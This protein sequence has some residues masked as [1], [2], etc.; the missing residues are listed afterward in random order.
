MREEVGGKRD[1]GRWKKEAGGRMEGGRRTGR[2]HG[3]ISSVLTVHR[4]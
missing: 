3:T 2:I 4:P 1:G